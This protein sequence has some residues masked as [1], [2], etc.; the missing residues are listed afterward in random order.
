M[1]YL[2]KNYLT[3]LAVN[4]LKLLQV[5]QFDPSSNEVA[6]MQSSFNEISSFWHDIPG[7]YNI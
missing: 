2:Y 7:L 4:F 1:F 5:E 6:E 3:I